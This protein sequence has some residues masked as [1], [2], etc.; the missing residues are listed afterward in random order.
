MERPTQGGPSSSMTVDSQQCAMPNID[1]SAIVSISLAPSVTVQTTR[2]GR[3]ALLR[4]LGQGGMGSV[5]AAYDEQLDRR[6]AI[7]LLH[8][9]HASNLSQRQQTLRE[10]RAAARISHPNVISVYEVGETEESVYIAM[11]YVEGESLQTWQTRGSRAWQEILELYLQASSGLAAAHQAGVVHRDFKPDNVLIGKDARPRVVDFGLARIDGIT[12]EPDIRRSGTESG[13]ECGGPERVAPFESIRLT[14]PGVISGTPGYMSPEQYRGGNVDE[15]S[16]QWSFCAAL[17]EA[18]Y[19][20]LP[21]FGKTLHES[22]QSVHGQPRLPPRGTKVPEEVHRTLLRGLAADP[23]QRFSSM[24]ELLEALSLEQG[25][26]AAGGTLLRQRMVRWFVGAVGLVM[27]LVQFRQFQRS[28]SYRDTIIGSVLTLAAVLGVGIFRRRTLLANRFHRYMW[29]LCTATLLENLLQRLV[30][31]ALGMPVSRIF[32]FEMIV[33]ASNT[34]LAGI[35]LIRWLA[36]LPAIPIASGTLF[37]TG[38]APTRVLSLTYLFVAI[39]F[40][41]GWTRAAKQ[42][43][44]VGATDEPGLSS[45]SRGRRTRSRSS[46]LSIPVVSLWER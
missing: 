44:S 28:L 15:R 39:I 23:D 41:I 25:D 30:G 26:H 43:K 18:L 37:L 27:A 11:E 7:K 6:V 13:A 12:A 2:I 40:S 3:F 5:F 16:D 29:T 14:L 42:N 38:L 36:W 35:F 46:D 34:A 31:L 8:R 24:T 21:F 32:P 10:A 1:S 17:F 4:Q 9:T 20:E 33:L 45:L 19:G 22:A